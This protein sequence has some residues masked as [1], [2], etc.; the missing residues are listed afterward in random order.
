MR[1][2]SKVAPSFWTGRTG[3]ALRGQPEAQIV[4]MY[5]LTCPH[6]TMTGVFS[7]PL[8]YIAHETGLPLEEASKGLRT[9]IEEGFCTYEEDL[10]LVWV[11]KMACYQIGDALKPN[12]NRV[13]GVRNAY[14]RIPESQIRRGFL[15]R[16]REAYLLQEEPDTAS[17]LQAPPKPLASQKQKQKQK[18]EQKRE[19]PPDGGP[20]PSAKRPAPSRGS[21]LPADW[22][23]PQDWEA[24]AIAERPD[25]TATHVRWCAEQFRDYWTAKVGKDASKADWYATWRTWVRREEGTPT[26]AHAGGAGA[27]GERPWMFTA[28]GIEAKAAELGYRPP[29]DVPLGIWKHDVYH[30]AGVTL[31]DLKQ[32]N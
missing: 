17:P 15:E 25:W 2:Y 8:V 18:Q 32:A 5:L 20:A 30:L 21:R 12:D 13:V 1:D 4:A 29:K 23:L 6:A 3:R 26:G 7:C 28:G 24:W 9:L 10:E 11:H 22:V 27:T 31:E 16:Y 19:V 14:E